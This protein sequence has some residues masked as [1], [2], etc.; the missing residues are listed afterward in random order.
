[1]TGH[2]SEDDLGSTGTTSLRFGNLVVDRRA[3]RVFL[4]GDRID[5]TRREFDLFVLLAENPERVFSR[6]ELLRAVWQTNPAWQSSAT[7]TEHV[8]RLRRKLGSDRSLSFRITS[9]R[10]IG[11][12]FESLGPAA[13]PDTDPLSEHGTT[14]CFLII[15]GNQIVVASRAALDLLGAGTAEAVVGHQTLEFIAD[16][17][18][19]VVH[20]RIERR[21]ADQLPRPE[22][23]WLRRL[24]GREV[25]ADISTIAITWEARLHHQVDLWPVP[26]LD[27][28]QLRK[29]A[30]GITS[31]VADAVIILDASWQVQTLNAAAEML[32]GWR[33]HE[34][35][36]QP[37]LDVIPST[38]SPPEWA[39]IAEI[40][41]RDGHWHGD[42][43]QVRRDSTTVQVHISAAL[44]GEEIGHRAGVVLVS[45]P[46]RTTIG[47]ST[48]GPDLGAEVAPAI[49]A[50]EFHPYYQPI[51]NLETR[52]VIGVEALA[53]WHHP[54]RGVLGP[55][56]FLGATERTGDII[57]LGRQLL[58]ESCIQVAEWRRTGLDIDLAVNVSAQQL[59]GGTLV[60]DVASTL[61]ASGL[62]PE[63]LIIEITETDLI[64][65]VNRAAQHLHE[66]ADR[67]VRFAIDDFG[68]GWASLTYLKRFPVHALKIDRTFTLGVQDKPSDIAIVRSILS[69][70]NELDLLVI[71]EGIETIDQESAMRE[72][73]CWI[74]Q[75]YLFA[76]PRPAADAVLSI[77]V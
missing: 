60:D 13:Q 24:D 38:M 69:L 14:H 65:D 59:L 11:Y 76:E 37:L 51:V 9:V 5:L 19:P 75:G 31:E 17:S 56:S 48:D 72:L 21:A 8:S 2:T 70:G 68:T 49:D 39:G 45:R 67:G 71:A 50:G 43:E 54:I 18:K 26:D 20:Q 27:G 62:E 53:R 25:L 12:Q 77:D 64:M 23:V 3:R 34:A 44:M 61:A 74:A 32:Y 40:L 47:G 28:A 41:I 1:M 73:G 33:E 29:A 52:R 4:Q 46:I 10:G 58:S 42:A 57:R 36:G 7:I 66:M 15:D 30:I 63:Q 6:D 22:T 16:R 35:A 55:T